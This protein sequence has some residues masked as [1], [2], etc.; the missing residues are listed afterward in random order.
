[1]I[2]PKDIRNI[3]RSHPSGISFRDFDEWNSMNIT[4]NISEILEIEKKP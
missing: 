1:L 3:G 4:A 2:S